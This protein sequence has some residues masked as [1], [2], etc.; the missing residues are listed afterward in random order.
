MLKMYRKYRCFLHLYDFQLPEQTSQSIGV[1]SVLTRQRA[2]KHDV[3]K[4]FFAFFQ[5]VLFNSRIN[6]LL[7]YFCHRSSGL[8]KV[9]SRNKN[10]RLHLKSTFCLSQSLRQSC[11]SKNW[12][13]CLGPKMLKL[14][15]FMNVPFFLPAQKGPP[16]S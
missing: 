6:S 1:C 4:Q 13:G 9:L 14:Q 8:Q 5:L 3:L 10:P 11:H 2:K 16:P 12:G 7:L 15:C